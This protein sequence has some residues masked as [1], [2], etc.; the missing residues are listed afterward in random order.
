FKKPLLYS[1]YFG[2]FF[3]ISAII[4]SYYYDLPT[5]YSIVF[6]GAFLTAITV[7]AKSKKAH[8]S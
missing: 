6:L 2:W 5:G 3:S 1:F 4:L 8:K 7:L